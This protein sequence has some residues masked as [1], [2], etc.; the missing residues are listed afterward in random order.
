MNQPKKPAPFKNKNF[1]I[2]LI[3]LLMLFVMFPMTGKDSSKD[4]TR[5]EFL[6][7]M[8]DS[9]KIITE[10][11][12]QKTPDGVIIEGA[13]EMSPEEIAEAKKSQ[14]ALARFTRNSTDTK[15][16]HFKSHMLDIS[17]EQISTW[18]A[19][20]G[21]KV[22]VIHES[23]TWIDTLVAFLPAILLIAFFYIMMS[24]QMG[25]GG[26]SPF[27]F[28]KSQVR[29]L[30]SQKKTTFN[31]VAGCDE[32]KQDLQ[33]L[34]EFLK[35]PKKYDKLGGRIPKGALLVG[36]PGTG[37]TLLARA[38]AGEAGVPF[39]SMS[40]SD[41]V[42]MFVGVG[43]SRVRDLFET[44]KK[45]APCIL[46]IDEIDAVG[47]QRGA[48]LGG[49]HDEREQTLNQLLVEMDGFTANEGVI[50]IAATNRPDVLDKA[51]L[52]PG[53]FDRQIVVGLPD[54]KGREEILKVHLKK[55]KVPLGDDV[56]VKAVAKG[57]PGLAGADLENLVNEAA[58]LA[59]RFNNKKVTMLDFEEA[60]D[61]L[62]MGAERRT[63]LM[64][65]EEKRHTAY[66]EAGHALMTLL[67]KHSD[68]LHKITI[69]PR[70]RAL[71]VT[72][73]LP[74][75]DQVSYSREYAEERIMI[76]MSGRLAELIFFN[77]Q[78]TGASNDI[79]RATELA[80]KMVTE[81]GFDEE[82]GPV[83]YSRADGEVFLGREISKPK[84]MSEMMA[85]KIDN[86]INNL[87]KRM[88]NK[89]RELLEENKDKLTD[90]AEALFE[91]EVLDREEIDKVMAGEKLTGTKKSR[92]YKA[93]EEL[94]KKREEENTPPPDP[95]DQPPV[96]PIADVQPAPAAGNETATNSVKGN[97]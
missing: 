57:T 56:D 70:G 38:V 16:K 76:M 73:S 85:E 54:L 83:C 61:K 74:E 95:G 41:F 52:R 29:Q 4:I 63:L 88:D 42:E 40:G 11:T 82:I 36:P 62:S 5:T 47:R 46:F 28:G 33:E 12:L 65:D 31:D 53:R 59:A 86:A 8:G 69:I 93:M 34:V 43:A 22:K 64:T 2:V 94:A 91:F 77:H 45:N 75:R 81:W 79:Q 10:L 21:V 1:I 25:G 51:L 20:K 49:G 14:S 9:T 7:M 68:P 50:L 15:N 23:T 67:C 87:I 39:F 19:F 48:G 89:A 84:E 35:D 60:R 66:H 92:Q 26:K 78:S 3:M 17:N 55:R 24:R 71:G 80:R 27:S 30:N 72:M 18:E 6:A 97:E 58:L 32:A 90:L 37:K 96:A 44:G 13:Y